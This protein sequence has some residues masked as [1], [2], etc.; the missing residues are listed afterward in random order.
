M[1]TILC[2]KSYPIFCNQIKFLEITIEHPVLILISCFSIIMSFNLCWMVHSKLSHLVN[3][4]VDYIVMYFLLGIW[5]FMYMLD[6]C[7][8]VIDNI[9]LTITILVEVFILVLFS[10]SFLNSSLIEFTHKYHSNLLQFIRPFV[11]C[12]IS[13]ICYILIFIGYQI[14]NVMFEVLWLCSV[15]LPIFISLLLYLYQIICSTHRFIL[16]VLFII[17]TGIALM[18]IVVFFLYD[19]NKCNWLSPYLGSDEIMMTCI[20]SSMWLFFRFFKKHK[21][22]LTNGKKIGQIEFEGKLVDVELEVK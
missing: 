10:F 13:V 21:E 6:H 5:Y 17:S 19:K 2:N 4:K 18:G 15:F 9:K 16:I 3:G 20:I 7:I 8:F 22:E 1:K 14:S 11:C 12:C